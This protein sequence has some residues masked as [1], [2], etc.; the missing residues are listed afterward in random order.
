ME[1]ADRSMNWK[2]EGGGGMRDPC[3]RADLISPGN[4][5]TNEPTSFV[6]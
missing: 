1:I 6:E 2:A 3:E 4:K 5:S